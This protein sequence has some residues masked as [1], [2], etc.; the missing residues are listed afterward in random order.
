METK[1][2]FEFINNMTNKIG[3]INT[4]LINI[5]ETLNTHPDEKTITI[6]NDALEYMEQLDQKLDTCRRELEPEKYELIDTFRKQT[7]RFGSIKHGIKEFIQSQKNNQ[8]LL[9]PQLKEYKRIQENL[10]KS[11]HMDMEYYDEITNK[12]ELVE[13]HIQICESCISESK[14]DMEICEMIEEECEYLEE[15]SIQG[16]QDMYDRFI[17]LCEDYV[18]FYGLS[19]DNWW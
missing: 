1:Q 9:E 19:E 5:S 10:E 11:T 17:N 8:Q 15:Y 4:Q 14:V 2:K 16:I 3:K 12:V 7:Y 13:E 6:Y 18:A